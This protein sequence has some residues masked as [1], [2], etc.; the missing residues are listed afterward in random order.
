VRDVSQPFTFVNP[1]GWDVTL[2]RAKLRIGP[3]YLNHAVPISQGRSSEGYSGGRYIAEVESQLV[4]DALSPDPADFDADGEAVVDVARTGEVWLYP[5]GSDD[6][7]PIVDVAGVASRGGQT[8]AFAGTIAIDSSW[9][10]PSSPD[11]PGEEPLAS[12]RQ[13]PDVPVSFE[14]SK[15]GALVVRVDPTRWF[16]AVSDFTSL[17]PNGQDAAGNYKLGA[18]IASDGTTVA[19]FRAVHAH[20]GVYSFEWQAR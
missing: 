10:T 14:T 2:T 20:Q 11:T 6:K 8:I 18:G 4:V 5:D 9:L 13:V 15:G 7:T 19:I 16:D 12:L 1:W 17:E 3:V